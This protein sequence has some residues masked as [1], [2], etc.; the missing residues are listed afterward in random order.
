[1]KVAFYTLGCKV[2]Q[3]ETDALKELFHQAGYTLAESEETADIYVV[4]SC[5]V[6]S[7]GERKSKQWLRR[8]KRLNADAVT[9]ITGCVPQAGELNEQTFDADIVTGT[10]NRRQIINLIEEYLQRKQPIVAVDATNNSYEELPFTHFHDKT[11]YFIK[12]QDG[13]DRNCSYCAIRLARGPARSRLQ[14]SIL[15]ELR[16]HQTP[17]EV[18]ITG[19]NLPAYGKDTGTD[20]SELVDAAAALEQVKRIRLSSLEPNTLTQKQIECF[21]AQPKLCHHFHLS[22]QSGC[23]ATLRRMRRT[24]TT[25]QYEDAITRLRAAMPGAS[26]TTDVIVGFP[27]EDDAEFKESLEFVLRMNFLKVHVFPY[28]ARPNTDAAAL[29]KQVEN[30]VKQRRARLMQDE[31]DAVRS[32][33]INR[34]LGSTATLLLEQGDGNCHTGYTEQYVPVELSTT[35][36]TRGDFVPVKLTSFNGH[37][38]NCVILDD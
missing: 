33:W 34:Q 25:A 37:H 27:G 22:L 20:L 15:D 38:C 8:A 23:D 9:V 10:V 24:Y 12:V 17:F 29:P 26:F 35:D 13:C 6:T 16:R 21:A 5:T 4:N 7:S 2:N 32:R 31:T 11:R 19:I 30:K 36:Y 1:M 18:V 3:V 14:Q 28:S